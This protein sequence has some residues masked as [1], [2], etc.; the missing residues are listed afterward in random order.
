VA[1]YAVLPYFT[2]VRFG[3]WDELLHHTAPPDSPGP[4]P[5]AI[6]HYARG[7]A[8]LRTGQPA[9]AQRELASL[10]RLAADP[11]LAAVKLKNI[12][13]VVPLLQ[14]AQRTLQADLAL[15]AGRHAEALALLRQA[16]ALEDGLVYD[17]PHLWL[18]PTRQAL[19]AALLDAGQPAE[20]EQVFLQDLR[21]YPDNGWSLTGLAQA[22]RR[23]GHLDQALDA[24]AR[25]RSAWRDADAPLSRPRY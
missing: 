17:E 24:E 19:G 15:A 5:L 6:W 7:T 2:R 12:N 25:L 9:A 1:H 18:A 10:Q 21:H 20:A 11:T 3:L 22:R 23:Q 16:T 13:P 14:I 4:Y 8:Y